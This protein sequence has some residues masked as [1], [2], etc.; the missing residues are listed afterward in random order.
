MCELGLTYG[1]TGND[2][3]FADLGLSKREYPQVPSTW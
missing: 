2:A 3:V 1:V